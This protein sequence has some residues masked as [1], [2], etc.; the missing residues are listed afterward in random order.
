MDKAKQLAIASKGGRSVPSDQRSF[1]KDP[2]LAVAAG[3]KGG[4]AVAPADRSFS[5]N[6]ELA[7]KAGRKGGEV[8]HG[9][10]ASLSD[11]KE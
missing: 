1:A 9:L 10:R 3:R 2:S 6:V 5:R 8:A 11:G 7:A 4:M